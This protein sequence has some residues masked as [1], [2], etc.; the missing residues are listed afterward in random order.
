MSTSES[1]LDWS[2]LSI[3]WRMGHVFLFIFMLSSL[4]LHLGH[5]EECYKNSW[6]YYG[7]LNNIDFKKIRLVIWLNWNLKNFVSPAVGGKQFKF[8]CS[9]FI[10][11]SSIKS[12]KNWNCTQCHS[13]FLQILT[14]FHFFTLEYLQ[15][16]LFIPVQSL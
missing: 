10:L 8:Q 1:S 7:S 11:F 15:S 13:L 9:S 14:P 3:N 4:V 16:L 2:I 6:F 12:Y 5:C